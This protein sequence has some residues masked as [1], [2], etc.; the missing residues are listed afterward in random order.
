MYNGVWKTLLLFQFGTCLPKYP[1]HTVIMPKPQE[2]NCCLLILLLYRHMYMYIA[3]R[4]VDLSTYD[5]E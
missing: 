5:V 1:Q 2:F 3:E 4:N